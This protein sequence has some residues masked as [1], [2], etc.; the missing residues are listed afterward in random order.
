MKKKIVNIICI[1][2]FSAF[3]IGIGLS[4]CFREPVKILISERRKAAQFPELTAESVIDKSFFDGLEEYFM[5]QF[6]LRDG[7]RSVKAAVQL[8]L[9]GQ[10]DVNGIYYVDGH[11]CELMPDLSENSVKSVAE[12]IDSITEKY[13]IP[14]GGKA[15]YS[16]IPDKNYYLAEKNGYPSIDYNKMIGILNSEVQ[17]AGYIDIID[18]LG[19]DNYY[20]TDSH[21]KQETISPVAE[22][23]GSK[24]GFSVS[25]GGAKAETLADFRGV[26]ASRLPL[27]KG[28]DKIVCM[29]SPVSESALVYNLETDKTTVGVY[30]RAK[31]KGNDKYDVYLSGAAALLTVENTLASSKKELV[32]FRDSFG[33]SLAP[34]LLEGYSKITLVDLRYFSS[35]LLGEYIDFTNADVLFIYNTQIINQS[36]LLK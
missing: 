10:K 19:I 7:F 13:V 11:I 20:K 28:E 3:L 9:L 33:S 35:Q 32:I 15:Y 2:C 23:L 27:A 25:P 36:S 18:T 21:W 16:V 22:R 1:I 31:L 30:D 8:R 6:P 17:N 14:S 4:F 5:D 29:T 24:M 12:K 34:L 26:Y